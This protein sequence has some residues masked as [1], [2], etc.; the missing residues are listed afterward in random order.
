MEE[1]LTANN[2]QLGLW[3]GALMW[4]LIPTIMSKYLHHSPM[5]LPQD[6]IEAPV[7]SKLH[8]L[9]PKQAK[10]QIHG[11]RDYPKVPTLYK[12]WDK[13]HTDFMGYP[14]TGPLLPIC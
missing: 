11:Q 7:N 4:V 10:Y 3:W 8:L 6:M 9:Q 1:A 5:M 14:K 2:R 13:S 12:P